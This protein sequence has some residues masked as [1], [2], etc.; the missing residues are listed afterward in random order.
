[1]ALRTEGE[2]ARIREHIAALKRVPSLGQARRWW[3][4]YLFH[5]TDIR[6]VVRILSSG[7]LLSRIQAKSLNWLEVDIAAPEIIAN[8]NLELQDHVRLYFR[9]RTPTQFRNEG[10]RPPASQIYQ[11]HCPVPVY[12]LFDSIAV[13]SRDDSLFTDGNAASGSRPTGN[14][15]E[16]PQVRFDLVYHDTWFEPDEQ[17]SIV[18]HRNAEV[19]V[20]QRL[21]LDNLRAIVCRS[22]A[23]YQTLL[24]L[25]PLGA[26]SRWVEKISVRQDLRLFHNKWT[27]VEQAEMSNESAVFRFNR[28]TE[29]PGPF[30]AR[31]EIFEPSASGSKRYTWQDNAYRADDV[32]TLRLANLT[33]PSD[34]TLRL[35]LDGQLA[36]AN[37]FQEEPLPF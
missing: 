37:R 32:L 30:D 14:V 26:K 28:S 29:T 13:L 9:P 17:S 36:F 10:F 12:L 19:L 7:E 8:T 1:M 16:L 35:T 11:A 5:S 31:V 27:F 4:N 6:N 23:E 21:Q 18:Y 20:P 2:I 34:Y 22:Q 15:S 3:P 25:L 33:D 24:Y